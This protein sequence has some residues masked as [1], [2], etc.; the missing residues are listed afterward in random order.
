MEDVKVPG[1]ISETKRGGVGAEGQFP[2][3]RWNDS[4]LQVCP[5]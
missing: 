3:G 4:P 5:K 2:D 1:S